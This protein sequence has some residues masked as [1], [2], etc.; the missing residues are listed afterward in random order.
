MRYEVWFKRNS[1]LESVIYFAQNSEQAR[2]FFYREF[3]F[4]RIIS[5]LFAL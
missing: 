5:V 1:T 2:E 3:G 4:C